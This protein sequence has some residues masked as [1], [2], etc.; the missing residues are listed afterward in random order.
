[1]KLFSCPQISMYCLPEKKSKKRPKKHHP[2]HLEEVGEEGELLLLLL[3]QLGHFMLLL[4]TYVF[5]MIAT[6]MQTLFPTSPKQT[7]SKCWRKEGNGFES[8]WTGIM[9][10]GYCLVIKLAH[11]S[12]RLTLQQATLL[13]RPKKLKLHL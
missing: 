8:S 5:V 12:R 6:R 1:M 11:W 13:L 4:Q 3:R 10:R 9:Q 2:L 7:S